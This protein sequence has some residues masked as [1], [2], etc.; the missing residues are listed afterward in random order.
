MALHQI[1]PYS[2][3]KSRSTNVIYQVIAGNCIYHGIIDLNQENPYTPDLSPQIF[4]KTN[5]TFRF[6]GSGVY[7]SYKELAEEFPEHMEWFLARP[8]YLPEGS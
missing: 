7:V 1:V 4:S 2:F 5:T 6:S 3:W 8:T